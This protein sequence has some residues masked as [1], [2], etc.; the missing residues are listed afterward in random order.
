MIQIQQIEYDG[1]LAAVVV[2][3]EATILDSVDER[4][5]PTVK[6]MCLYAIEVAAGE[7]PGPYRQEAAIAFAEQA[8]AQRAVAAAFARQR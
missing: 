5:L 3:Q 6:A 1:R 2:D 8:R 7:R 4:A